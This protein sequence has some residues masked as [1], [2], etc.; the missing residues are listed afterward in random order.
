[1]PQAYKYLEELPL[2]VQ[3]ALA[4]AGPAPCT[5]TCDRWWMSNRWM[6]C[7]PLGQGGCGATFQVLPEDVEAA[8]DVEVAEVSICNISSI[9]AGAS[10]ELA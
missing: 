7:V 2:L 6:R 10:A 5:P 1:M 3:R 8:G 4:E 9:R